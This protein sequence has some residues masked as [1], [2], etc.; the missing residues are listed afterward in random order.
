MIHQIRHIRRR[1]RQILQS[2]IFTLHL[3]HNTRIRPH[4]LS[5]NPNPPLEL[6]RSVNILIKYP[7]PISDIRFLVF[8][9]VIESVDLVLS[10]FPIQNIEVL[11]QRIQIRKEKVVINS[12]LVSPE[13]IVSSFPPHHKKVISDSNRSL[14]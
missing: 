3:V 12:Q 14:N 1:N 6:L 5:I 13:I 10:K 2:R 9:P 7:L 11:N 8:S 4:T